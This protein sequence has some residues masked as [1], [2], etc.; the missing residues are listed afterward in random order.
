MIG[1]LR[2]GIADDD[3]GSRNTLR[4]MLLSLGH[5]V[6]SLAEDG[7]QLVAQCRAQH[8]DLVVIDLEMPVLDGLAAAEEIC[9][10]EHLPIILVSG[11]PDFDHVVR[12]HEPFAAFL[13]KPV[14]LQRLRQAVQ[15]AMARSSQ[16]REPDS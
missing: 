4:D 2:I 15:D 9:A 10:A 8:P 14:T 12:R 1:S 5:S 6:V 13:S 7:E 16:Q 3:L 11:H